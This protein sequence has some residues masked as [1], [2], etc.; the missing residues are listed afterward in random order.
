[1]EEP[2]VDLLSDPE[3]GIQDDEGTWP[4]IS[5]QICDRPKQFGTIEGNPVQNFIKFPEITGGGDMLL[6]EDRRVAFER[7]KDGAARR[8][9]VAQAS[10]GKEPI[11]FIP[12][13]R[14]W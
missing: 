3:G 8:V 14:V 11:S 6:E 1:M 12:G 2:E 4:T 13:D 9:K 7:L 5:I 10:M